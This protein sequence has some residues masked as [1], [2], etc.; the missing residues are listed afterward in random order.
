MKQFIRA[1]SLGLFAA[2]IIIGAVY[3]IDKPSVTVSSPTLE[4]SIQQIEN[5]GYYVFEEDMNA[6]MNELNEQIDELKNNA[7]HSEQ[8]NETAEEQEP[9]HVSIEIEA[10][11]TMPDIVDLLVENKLIADEENFLNYLEENS[12]SRYVQ[13]GEFTLNETMS[14][15]EIANTLTR[16]N[17]E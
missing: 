2:T 10:G 16:Q 12:L 9:E 17:Q 3:F 5:E 6:K 7:T 1:F 13:I 11:M 8:A 14:A 4:D 15:E